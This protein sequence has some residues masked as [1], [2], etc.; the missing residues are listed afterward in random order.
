[1][2]TRWQELVDR[3]HAIRPE[4]DLELAELVPDGTENDVMLVGDDHVFRFPRDERAVARQQ[5]EAKL[6]DFIRRHVDGPLPELTL[7]AD[8]IGYYPY[9]IGVPLT[10]VQLQRLA[11]VPRRAVLGALGEMLRQ[12]HSIPLEPAIEAGFLPSDTYRS[13]ENWQALLEQVRSDLYPSMLPYQREWVEQHFGTVLRGEISLDFEP[14]IIH[15]DL[16]VYHI[17]YDP[18]LVKLAGVIDFGTV[19]LGDPAIDIAFLIVQYGET[20]TRMVLTAYPEARFFI[21]R[22]RFWAGTLEL[23]WALAGQRRNEP[24]LQLAHIGNARDMLP[25]GS[26]NG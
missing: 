14:A 22:A 23:Q 7:P 12:L 20:L 18:L 4:L 24:S 15:G 9:L 17:L 3:I 21:D 25:P 13:L 10:P 8:D 16:G 19:G 5:E 6:L 11:L 2:P 26:A 1:M